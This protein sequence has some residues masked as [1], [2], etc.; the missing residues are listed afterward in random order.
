VGRAGYEGGARV[1]EVREYSDTLL[2][3]ML[4]GRRPDVYRERH[5]VT[6]KDGK[7]LATTSTIPVR[8]T[9]AAGDAH[10]IHAPDEHRERGTGEAS[11]NAPER[12]VPSPVA[13]CRR[14]TALR[15]AST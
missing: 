7:P 4:K 12:P 10:T 14:H 3:A 5:E 8:L 2:L 9:T 13:Q 15:S 6:G 11:G 1:G